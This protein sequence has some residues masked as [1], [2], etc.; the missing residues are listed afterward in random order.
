[1]ISSVLAAPLFLHEVVAIITRR[2]INS[3]FM[4]L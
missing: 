3:L 2:I 4:V 1:M